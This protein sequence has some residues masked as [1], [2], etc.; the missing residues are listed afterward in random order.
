MCFKQSITKALLLLAV[1]LSYHHM[2]AQVTPEARLTK[3]GMSDGSVIRGI[4]DNGKWAVAYG[5]N[6]ATS[7][8][9]YPKLVDVENGVVTELLSASDA[10]SG[11]ASQANDVTD[12]GK[13]V[14]GG[15]S[16]TPAYYNT[17]TKQWVRL[18]VTL[19]NTGGRVMAVTPDGKYGVGLCTQGG[20]DEVP[21]MWNM[22]TGKQISTPNLPR[23]DLSGT[24]ENMTRFTGISA[25]GRYIVGCVDYSYPQYVMYFLYDRQT[26]SWDPIVFD[27]NADTNKFTA[28]KSGVLSL[29]GICIS[30]N[31]K[32]VSG[33]LYTAEDARCP[34][35]YS[36]ETKEVEYMMR[37]DDLDKGCVVIDDN[38]TIY[39]ATPAVSPSRSLYILHD[40]YWYGLDEL[41]QQRYGIDYYTR[42]GYYSTGL[43]SAISANGKV[44]AGMAYISEDNYVLELP[45]S[46]AEACSKVNL[47][48]T[49]NVTPRS[50]S[51]ITK[52]SNVAVKFSR[53]VA[54][55]GSVSDIALK[56]E[57]GNVV[58]S[59]LK[60]AAN[61]SDPRTVDIGFRTT[62]LDKGKTYN[63][64]I[65]AG[66]I[67]LEGDQTKTNAEI[68]IT[69]I[70]HG[71]TPIVCTGV[72][73]EEHS[74]V[75]HLD[76][77]TNP[78]VFTFDTD[79]KVADG[80]KAQLYRND[81]TTPICDLN[82]FAGTN[83]ETYN[84][85]IVYP[86]SSQSLY[87][88][89]TYRVVI[90]EGSISD[91]SGY[92]FNTEISVMYDGS[93][94]RTIVS[95][96]THIYIENFEGGMGNVMLYDGDKNT[97][98]A[99]MEAWKFN[100][101]TTAWWY[102]ADDDYT[103]T[104]AVSHSMYTPAG[105]SD[106][107]MVTPQ[108]YIPD[109]KCYLSF[110]AQS[111][112][113]GSTD[114]LKVIIYSTDDVYNDL[115]AAKIEKFRTEGNVVV[116]KTLSPGS[117]EGTLN[118]DWELFNID[119]SEYAGKN[120]YIAFVNENENQS[121]VFVAEVNVV[122]NM[123]MQIAL[124]GVPESGV[125]MTEQA[126]K[127][128]VTIKN[129]TSTYSSIKVQ[130]LDGEGNVVDEISQ[131]GLS[132]KAE[133]V[134]PFEFAKPLPLTSGTEN[135]F[136][137]YVELNG[138]ETFD[139]LVTSIR[140]LS[141]RPT[142][143]VVLE[144][145][146]G[147]ACPNCPLG[148]LAIEKLEKTYGD[149]FIPVTY[150]VYT[151]D[152]FESGMTDYATYYL[153][154]AAAPTGRINRGN[155]VS[156]MVSETVDGVVDYSFTSS[157]QK[158]WLETVSDELSTDA[159]AD[160]Y[161]NAIYDKATDVLSIP[162]AFKY[163]LD[164]SNLNVGMFFIITEDS[165]S[166]YQQNNLYSF[167]D[168][169]LGEWQK[170]GLYG[171]SIIYPYT[172]HDVARALYPS[173]NYS[174]M[175]GLVPT[176][177]ESNKDYTGT[178]SFGIKT[179][180]PYVSNI[181]NCKVVCMMIDANT[182]RVINVARAKVSDSTGIE[183]VE[184]GNG[185]ASI[186]VDGAAIVVTANGEASVKVIAADGRTLADTTVNGSAVIPVSYKG[187]AVVKVSGNGHSTVRKVVVR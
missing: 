92:S 54:V 37:A 11:T 150:H 173:S 14:V 144:E 182:G 143:R 133:D 102:A 137:V 78:V 33:V 165:L 42:T 46:F 114:K 180:A 67:C 103:N 111:Y 44:L 19:G 106:D 174:G 32:W 121:A 73:P 59:A 50:G 184:G 109:D 53:R 52:V 115:D 21:T 80:A 13:M 34:F 125:G 126:I 95:D 27:Y 66:T 31:G 83:S 113:F 8:Y 172:F 178:V 70:G 105:K 30:P 170:D 163:A 160:L 128:N 22:A 176:E 28:K 145:Y 179:N 35:R 166:G 47:L 97:P 156:P 167:Y 147:E 84:Q 91:E 187:V 161:I 155:I 74:T 55:T 56:D 157:T 119:L 71:D 2:L 36:T 1:A 186:S 69:Y 82:I 99:E 85:V 129:G 169:D 16:G 139:R 7:E 86:T 136:T 154:M 65:P 135:K 88:G 57:D 134:F 98:T 127:G 81:E 124:T 60:F 101:T 87:K 64:V 171:K 12:D 185:S 90:P 61:A 43:A 142:K 77:T 140:H 76:M 181:Y 18:E 29:D 75:G 138:G 96:N 159:D 26:E 4:S 110:K 23:V 68:T 183:G 5:S 149:R 123:D 132:L 51:C 100:S 48:S 39:A 24:Y 79:V 162:Y 164:M 168:D 63:I 130:L 177:V 72:A 38:G 93:Y 89:N 3:Y 117:S 141:F 45:E 118:G 62:A 17:E 10:E 175:R 153:G 9:S 151:G 120:I 49:Y 122:H 116:D 158:L 41:L 20:Y 107:W 131:D 148:H 146:T 6:G 112:R 152:S 15:I 25:D 104:C 94:E 40:N 108:L 58:K